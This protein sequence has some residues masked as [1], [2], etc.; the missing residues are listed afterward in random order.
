MATD[1]ICGMDVDPETAAD[2]FE[3]GGETYYFCVT[4][5]KEK[6]EKDPERVFTWKLS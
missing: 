1:P 5:C 3:Y 6:F 4:A 2:Q